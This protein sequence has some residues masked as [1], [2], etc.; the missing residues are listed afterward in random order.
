MKIN[1]ENINALLPQTQCEQ[2][3]YK[4]CKPYAQALLNG[5]AKTNLCAPGGEQTMLALSHLLKVEPEKTLAHPDA[6]TVVKSVRIN[7]DECIGCTKCLK[8][9]PT[10]AIVGGPKLMHTIIEAYCTG[11]ELCLPLCPTDCMQ[12]VEHD[13]PAWVIDNPLQANVAKQLKL[14]HEQHLDRKAKLFEEK[15][16]KDLA[17]QKN[18]IELE[19][20][21]CLNR[22]KAKHDTLQSKQNISNL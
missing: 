20:Q 7:E 14:R 21:A 19:I 3:G 6:K 10:D 1:I 18:K 13:S 2:C 11:C 16:Q 8:V 9:C 22:V 4:G 15:R 12:V 17:K 5:E